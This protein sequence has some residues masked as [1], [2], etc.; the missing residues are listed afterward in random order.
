MN[1]QSGVTTSRIV[2]VCSDHEKAAF[3]KQYTLTRLL[4][5]QGIAVQEKLGEEV[6]KEAEAAWA[7]IDIVTK[8]EN[9]A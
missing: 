7:M 3:I 9:D 5:L 1:E 2:E 8:E 4:S 6:V